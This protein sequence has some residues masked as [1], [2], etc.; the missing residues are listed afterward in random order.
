MTED[1]SNAYFMYKAALMVIGSASI[2]MAW[3]RKDTE[4]E[5]RTIIEANK[6][7]LDPLENSDLRSLMS[8]KFGV[9]VGSEITVE[10]ATRMREEI[11]LLSMGVERN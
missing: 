10:E 5:R 1:I 3:W 2:G 11:E 7:I 8:K 6:A 4:E 9:D